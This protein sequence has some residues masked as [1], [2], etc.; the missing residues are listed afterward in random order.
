MRAVWTI[1][2][3]LLASAQTAR[4]EAGD[5]AG[6][7]YRQGVSLQQKGDLAGART[8]YQKAMSLAPSRVDVV[9]NLALLELQA[10][11]IERAAL[12]FQKA[13]RI[14]PS[15]HSIRFYY[16]LALFKLERFE[17]ARDQLARS[18]AEPQ[19][20]AQALHLL[21][22][23]LLK[24][25]RLDEGILALKSCLQRDPSKLDAAYTL[26][27]AYLGN[28]ESD[29]VEDMLAG[30]F[31]G[32]RDPEVR[33]IRGAVLNRKGQYSQALAE[34][35]EARNL[36]PR[37]ATLHS[38]MALAYLR[39]GEYENATKAYRAELTVR[40]VDFLANAGLGWLALQE[41]RHDEAL[42]FIAAAQRQ[43]PH[44]GGLLFLLGQTEFS[45]ARYARAA[46]AL[47]AAVKQHPAHTP[48]HVMLARVYAKLKRPDDF[49]RQQ[50]IIRRLNDEE[51]ARNLS[52]QESYSGA[53]DTLPDFGKVPEPP[54]EKP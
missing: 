53:K 14:Q 26:A 28:G 54:Q 9:S 7:Y 15:L 1:L 38:E 3:F 24:L 22:L 43:R 32:K 20:G 33:L 35:A 39:L 48:A 41:K 31:A 11:N 5:P 4:P 17:H 30:V 16:G 44:N 51:Q 47:E 6:F 10:G 13:I 12:L 8:V 40:P 42:G 21:G 45:L 49:A 29:K 52:S 50:E 23:C 25:D 19:S 27:T 34:L 46:V 37:L 2:V 18:A 36:N